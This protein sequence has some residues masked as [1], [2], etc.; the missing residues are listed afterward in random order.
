MCLFS[1]ITC[2]AVFAKETHNPL[3]SC[4]I[5]GKRTR[6]QNFSLDA[7]EDKHPFSHCRAPLTSSQGDHTILTLLLPWARTRSTAA[8]AAGLGPGTQAR[9]PTLQAW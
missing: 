3:Q 4:E 2:A 5:R 6:R 1:G 9:A 8:N 7:Q